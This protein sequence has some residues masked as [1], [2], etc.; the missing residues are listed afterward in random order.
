MA[1]S[2][3]VLECPHCYSL[4]EVK[5]PDRVHSAFSF[6]VP[7]R[8]SFYGEVIKQKLVCQ[9]PECKKQ[10]IVYWYSPMDYFNRM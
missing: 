9:N 10:I 5:P 4:F 6:E 2:Q 3:L 8:G 7:V 1:L